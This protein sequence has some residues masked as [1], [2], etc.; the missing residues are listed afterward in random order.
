VCVECGKKAVRPST[1]SR[2][3]E[4]KYDGAMHRIPVRDMPIE[5]CEQ[6]GEEFFG[7][8]A[9]I[10]LQQALRNHLG[11]LQPEMIRANRAALGM[12]QKDLATLLRSAPESLSRWETAATVQSRSFDTMLRIVFG[13]PGAIQFLEQLNSDRSLG[14]ALLVQPSFI[15]YRDWVG[16]F[17]ATGPLSRSSPP[18]TPSLWTSGDSPIDP[19]MLSTGPSCPPSTNSSYVLAA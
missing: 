4:A 7:A 8:A 10:A 14:T 9:D 1:V 6:C 12:T 19:E 18:N 5:K 15:R 13:L 17:R 11:L 16:T 3:F 2:D